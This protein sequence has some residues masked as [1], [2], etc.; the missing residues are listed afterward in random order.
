VSEE[1]SVEARV[2]SAESAAMAVPA[3]RVAQVVLAAQA[4]AQLAGAVREQRQRLVVEQETEIGKAIQR[5][6]RKELACS[7]LARGKSLSGAKQ[8]GC[9]GA[10]GVRY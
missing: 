1:R 4:H 3:A 10:Q 2:G 6:W 5:G 8:T 9:F 7:R